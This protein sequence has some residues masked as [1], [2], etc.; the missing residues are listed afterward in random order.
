MDCRQERNAFG[1]NKVIEDKKE[2]PN[3]NGKELRTYEK[4][5]E[6]VIKQGATGRELMDQLLML[7]RMKAAYNLMKED[8]K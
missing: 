4:L 1:V 7:A 6:L 2:K 3:M 5:M 8:R